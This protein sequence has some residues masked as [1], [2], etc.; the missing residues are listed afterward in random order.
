MTRV[1]R[2]IE[3]SEWLTRTEERLSTAERRLAAAARPAQ[4]STAVITGPNLL[5]NPGYEGKRLDG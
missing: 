1:A 3:L 5:P 4:G 2:S